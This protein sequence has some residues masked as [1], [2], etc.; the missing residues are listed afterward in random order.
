MLPSS[1][2]LP[3]PEMSKNAFLTEGLD[4]FRLSLNF[5][6]PDIESAC[7]QHSQVNDNF[8]IFHILRPRTGGGAFLN[9][10]LPIYRHARG[11]V[12]LRK[13]LSL[14]LSKRTT[15]RSTITRGGEALSQ[16]QSHLVFPANCV[17]KC[18][19]FG[20]ASLSACLLV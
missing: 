18:R 2:K 3:L 11:K 8:I 5:V 20:E 7:I 19:I 16:F 12:T 10:E 17:Q 6:E 14:A 4:M 13:P 1:R 9:V 15:A